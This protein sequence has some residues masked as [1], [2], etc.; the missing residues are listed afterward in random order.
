MAIP[1]VRIEA[2]CNRSLASAQKVCQGLGMGRPVE[3]PEEILDDPAIDAVVIGTWPYRHAPF[4]IR[5]LERGKHVLTEAR[6]AMNAAEAVAMWDVSCR[7]PDLVAQ[8]VPAPF[9]LAYDALILD[10]VQRRIGRLIAVRLTFHAGSFPDFHA[11]WHWRRDRRYS[12]DNALRMGILYETALRWVGPVTSL[13]AQT[14][15]VVDRFPGAQSGEPV[16]VEIPD[17][18]QVLGSLKRDGASFFLSDSNVLGLESTQEAWIHGTEGTIRVPFFGVPCLGR[19]G[20]PAMRP[21][22][23][24]E[25]GADWR[26]EE[27][28]VGAIRGEEKVCLNTFETAVQYMRFT[29]A[30][31]ESARRGMPV[32]L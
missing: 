17:H 5:A 2:V 7:H 10:W 30:V 32:A 14:R 18:I 29:G 23:G 27:E 25:K 11:P 12:G 28:F 21:A 1:G 15:I 9:T 24:G 8:V 20:D 19:K 26:V 3:R 16:A 13:F 4:A 31:L 22:S 6:M